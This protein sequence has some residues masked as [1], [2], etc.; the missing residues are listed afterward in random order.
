M[1]ALRAQLTPK[2]EALGEEIT[3]AL[4]QA[5]SHP[6]Y[7]HVARHMRRRVNP[8]KDTWVALSESPRGYKMMPHVEFGL[9][10]DYAFLRVG[11]LYEAHDRRSFAD[12]A[13]SMLEE[14]PAG[15][16][17][18]FDHMQQAAPL[19]FAKD[20]VKSEVDRQLRRKLG[21]ILVERRYPAGEIVG[22]DVG[23]LVVQALPTLVGVYGNWRAR[24]A[25]AV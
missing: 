24:E 21:D 7:V 5:V 18:V 20:D 14:L 25:S 23:A 4:A 15:Y 11:V 6:F 16:G 9:F 8:P 1:A 12:A 17:F 3:P 2:L 10:A 19:F 13:L 22:H